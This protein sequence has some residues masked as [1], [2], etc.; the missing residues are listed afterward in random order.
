MRALSGTGGLEVVGS[1]SHLADALPEVRA[2]GPDVA[3]VIE[4][5]GG[6]LWLRRVSEAAPGVRWIVVGLLEEDPALLSWAQAGAS[7]FV[8]REA[9][10]DT[11]RRAIATVADEGASCS[12]RE[13]AILLQGIVASPVTPSVVPDPLTTRE[14]EI[15]GLVG[16][17]LSNQQIA[18]RLHIALPTVKNHVHHIL[19]KLGAPTRAEAVRAMRRTGFSLGNARHRSVQLRPAA[20]N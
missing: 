6:P 15:L 17:G 11:L 18:H 8:G 10:F 3:L 14:L 4:G 1:T 2:L 13:L 12:S 20:V 5:A 16:Q 19:E 9:T 7:G